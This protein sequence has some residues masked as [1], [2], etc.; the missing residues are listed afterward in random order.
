MY[1]ASGKPLA[2][3]STPFQGTFF[4]EAFAP[5]HSWILFGLQGR[6]LRSAD[7]GAHWTMIE[8]GAPVGIDAGI[9]LK[10]GSLRRYF[11]S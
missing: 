2:T 6:V 5:D 3:I 8:A 10:D 4:G 9:V 11:C 1:G 7:Q